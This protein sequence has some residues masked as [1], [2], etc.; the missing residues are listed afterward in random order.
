MALTAESLSLSSGWPR[1]RSFDLTFIIGTAALAL[2]SGAVV[3]WNP[4]LFVPVLVADL[5]L[6]GYHHVV[7]TFARLCFPKESFRRHRFLAI[8]LPF[9]VLGGVLLLGAG[10]G[11]WALTSLCLYWQWFIYTRQS[12]GIAQVY[13]R[14]A[15]GLVADGEWPGKAVFWVI[16]VWGILHRSY[17]DP[18]AFLGIELRV[19]PIPEMVVDVAE[20]AALLS[21][22]WWLATRALA[23]WRGRLALAHSLFMVSHFAVFGVAYVFV[24]DITYGWL[25]V[26]IWHNAQYAVF[27]WIFNTNRFRDGGDAKAG[28][29]SRIS[30][31][32]KI[33]LYFAVCVGTSTVVYATLQYTAALLLPALVI[34]QSINFHRYVADAVIRRAHRKPLRKTLGIAG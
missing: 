14:K 9:L 21:L 28:Y 19:L 1:E 3:I 2:A 32:E 24:E 18:G 6:L 20:T 31:P 5:W 33:W 34:Y 16:P 22:A 26:N 7:A 10:A 23:W 4:T 29:L 11:L 13:R 8:W 27:V 17:Q 30:P 12:W 15:D 25:V